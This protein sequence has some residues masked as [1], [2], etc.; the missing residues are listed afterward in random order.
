MAGV[1]CMLMVAGLLEG[2][3]RQTV[4]SDGLRYGIGLAA[5]FGWLC[6]FYL[7]RRRGERDALAV[8]P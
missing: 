7:P 3:G 5:L 4:Q 8:Q 1:V 6:Y 2:I